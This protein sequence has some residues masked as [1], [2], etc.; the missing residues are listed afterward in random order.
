MTIKEMLKEVIATILFFVF[1]AEL[2]LIYAI[3][4]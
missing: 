3:F 4:G 1:V 2:I